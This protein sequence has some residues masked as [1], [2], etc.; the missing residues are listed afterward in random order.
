MLTGSISPNLF[1]QIVRRDLQLSDR[2]KSRVSIIC[3]NIDLS[4]FIPLQ[5]SEDLD[6]AI[7]QALIEAFFK[8]KQV[9]RDSDCICRIS[10]LGFWVLVSGINDAV[11]RELIARVTA[12]LPDFFAIDIS[13]H[14]NGQSQLDWYGQIDEL[15]FKK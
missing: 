9:F 4:R 5:I 1:N 12:L 10:Q 8:L 7:E 14:I 6:K 2:S 15:H 11:S 3:I 13:H